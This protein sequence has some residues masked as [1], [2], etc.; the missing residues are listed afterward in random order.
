MGGGYCIVALCSSP[1]PKPCHV[2]AAFEFQTRSDCY[3]WACANLPQ[4][5]EGV[6]LKQ[7]HPECPR[8]LLV[9]WVMFGR[10]SDVPVEHD[11]CSVSGFQSARSQT[12]LEAFSRPVLQL[13]PC[14][15]VGRSHFPGSHQ[16]AGLPPQLEA[17]ESLSCKVLS[18]PIVERLQA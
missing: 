7:R 15:R 16:V 10:A 1:P 3:H 18:L 12:G 5:S 14:V 11:V 13:Q 17:E 2:G 8:S 6:A 9:F 4:R